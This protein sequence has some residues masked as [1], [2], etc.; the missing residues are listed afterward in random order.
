MAQCSGNAGIPI[1]EVFLISLIFG[2]VSIFVS[3]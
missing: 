2:V 3:T 1:L